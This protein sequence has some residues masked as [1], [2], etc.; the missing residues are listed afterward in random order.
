MAF[1]IKTQL[2]IQYE[3]PAGTWNSIQADSFELEIDRG[4]DVE[5]GVLAKPSIGT[6]TIKMMK[7]SMADFINGPAYQSNQRI[8]I[9]WQNISTWQPL[10]YGFIQN[11]EMAYVATAKVSGN[12]NQR[13][14]LQ[15]TLTAYDMGKIALNTLVPSFTTGASN[16]TRSYRGVMAGLASAITAIDSR[17]SQ[18]QFGSTASSTYQ[19]ASYFFD[20]QTAGSIYEKFLDA[21]LGWLW[22]SPFS[23]GGMAYMTRADVATQKALSWDPT[24]RVVVSN[25]HSLS[26]LHSCMDNIQLSYLSDGIANVVRVENELTPGFYT[27]RT[28]ST[29]VTAYGS[30]VS[31]FSV[32]FDPTSPSSTIAQWGDA[33][34]AAANPK[35]ITQVS[36][37]VLSDLGVPS[38]ILNRDVGEPLQVEFAVN[39]L[40]TLQEQYLMTRHN[41]VITADHW[42][43]N[44]SLWRGI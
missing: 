33:V 38:L 7:S 44:I 6:A 30:Q 16:S 21:E 22:A 41:H 5:A 39:G 20:P 11:I 25:V 17:Y 8:R 27:T 9:E 4:I 23:S 14:K 42:E 19:Q 3:S 29:S 13:G 37:P 31:E 35:A 24:G 43:L 18:S 34:T 40:T 28:N 32:L 2:R 26:D 36:V 15:V 10:F 1:D 12:S